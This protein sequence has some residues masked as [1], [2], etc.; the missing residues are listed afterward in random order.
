[1]PYPA[2]RIA[3][4]SP[5]YRHLRS[6]NVRLA[7]HRNY[8]RRDRCNYRCPLIADALK[9]VFANFVDAHLPGARVV[10]ASFIRCVKRR[11]IILRNLKAPF[12]GG[13]GA[14]LYRLIV[15]YTERGVSWHFLTS[16]TRLQAFIKLLVSAHYYA[17]HVTEYAPRS[18]L[19]Y[20]TRSRLPGISRPS[21]LPARRRKSNRSR[22]CR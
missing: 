20:C 14:A 8:I 12:V 10:E 5:F 3:S 21:F 4:Y 16:A 13:D 7:D 18:Y 15:Q 19:T 9:S 1:M 17:A 11:L 6:S 2:H 22:W